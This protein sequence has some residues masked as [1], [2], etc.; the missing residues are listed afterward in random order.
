MFLL[1]PQSV[2]IDLNTSA[3]FLQDLIF[4]YPRTLA[5]HHTAGSI[6]QRAP[7]TQAPSLCRCYFR[8]YL[9]LEGI[10]LLLC[11]LLSLGFGIVRRRD[12]GQPKHTI[13]DQ[14]K[15]KPIYLLEKGW[16]SRDSCQLECLWLPSF[17]CKGSDHRRN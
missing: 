9:S 11:A 8:G 14:V 17:D 16:C 12:P 7:I 1:L 3:Q 5:A 15:E 13:W 2:I 6:Q 10:F 4:L